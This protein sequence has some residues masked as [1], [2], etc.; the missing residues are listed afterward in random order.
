[1]SSKANFAKLGEDV[2]VAKSEVAAL[3][4]TN[5][6][7]SQYSIPSSGRGEGSAGLDSWWQI[8]NRGFYHQ[9]DLSP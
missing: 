1:M 5:T 2:V 8:G 7:N 4:V 3:D 9:K 6:P